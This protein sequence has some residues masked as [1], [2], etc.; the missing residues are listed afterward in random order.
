MRLQVPLRLEAAINIVTLPSVSDH[1]VLFKGQRNARQLYG[2]RLYVRYN[3]CVFLT[4]SL[5]STI[6]TPVSFTW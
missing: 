6:F 2:F 3:C 5:L 1:E 4:I